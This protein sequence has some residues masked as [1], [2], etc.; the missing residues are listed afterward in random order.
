MSL[1]LKT[2]A[3]TFT[4]ED[5]SGYH[6]TV[7]AVFDP[8]FGWTASVSMNVSGIKTAEDAVAYLAKPAEHFLRML[9]EAEVSR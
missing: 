4:V 2:T 3:S 9:R 1:S 6:F 7:D 5:E 8:E